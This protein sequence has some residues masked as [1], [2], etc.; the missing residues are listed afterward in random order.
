MKLTKNNI[1]ELNIEVALTVEPSDY[2]ENRKK[3]L[4]DIRRRAEIK[5]FRK[6]MVPASLI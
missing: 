2:A 6:G 4:S 5:G 1:D 3:K